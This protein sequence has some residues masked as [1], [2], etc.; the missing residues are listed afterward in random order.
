MGARA[1]AFALALLSAAP[2]RAAART[3]GWEFLAKGR[4]AFA[5]TAFTNQLKRTPDDAR[6]HVGLGLAELALGNPET[7]CTILLDAIK[8]SPDD[9]DAH[10]GLARAFLLRA[11]HRIATGRADDET[12]FLLLDAE[13]QGERA[14]ELKT[15]D[16]EAWVV[17]AEA[18]LEQGKFDRAETAIGEA[19][20]RGLDLARKRRLRGELSY[21][22]VASGAQEGSEEKF[23]EARDTL[24]ALLREDPGAIDI[25]LRLGDLCH[26][27]GHWNEALEAWQAGLVVEPFDRPTL[28][29]LLTYLR[30]PELRP[31]ARVVIESVAAAAERIAGGTDPRPAY[32]IMCVGH[33]KLLDRDLDGAVAQFKKAQKLDPSLEVECSLGLADADYHSQRYDEAAASF[34]RAFKANREAATTLVTQ[35]GTGANVSAALQFLAR[36]AMEKGRK[37]EARELLAIAVEFEAEN[38]RLWNDY[39]FLCR[40]SG[41]A[42][43]S[44]TAY[45]RTI[46]LA[47]DN[48]RYLNDAALILQDYLKKDFARARQ[49]YERAIAA[50]DKAIADA[51]TTQVVRDAAADARKD[52]VSNL[53]RLPAK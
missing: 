40:E 43:E 45:S 35:I 47:P 48:P 7:A 18:R 41:K 16:P 37:D 33:C 2:A 23:A 21:F 17:V 31:R 44:W 34:L 22:L 50:A 12:R 29:L 27:Y 24:L 26:A 19:E 25:R 36:R 4:P 28:D 38:P 15:D 49:L 53:A 9:R 52:A 32:A 14:A 20:K 10:L 39:A 8:H 51:T 11:R 6:A 42:Q 5:R 1:L 13:S 30:A 46:E 3:D